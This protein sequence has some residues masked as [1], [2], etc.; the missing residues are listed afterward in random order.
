MWT[1]GLVPPSPKTHIPTLCPCLEGQPASHGAPTTHTDVPKPLH[2]CSAPALAPSLTDARP[3]LQS[4]CSSDFCPSC[5]GCPATQSRTGFWGTSLQDS[6]WASCT[7]PRVSTAIPRLP[8]APR[9]WGSR[10]QP[11]MT[12]L[13]V[14][15]HPGLAYALLAGLPPVTGLYSSFYPVFLYFF[16]GTSRHNSVGELRGHMLPWGQW[17]G[18]KDQRGEPP[19]TAEHCHINGWEGPFLPILCPTKHSGCALSLAHRD[20]CLWTSERSWC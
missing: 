8:G 13:P 4:P 10:T 12:C 14:P 16:F 7:C 5:A 17:G 1:Q 9:R 3:P 18:S 15:P 19:S 2:L 6:A 20:R 11:S